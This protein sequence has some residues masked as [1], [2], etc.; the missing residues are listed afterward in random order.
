[1]HKTSIFIQKLFESQIGMTVNTILSHYFILSWRLQK[2]YKYIRNI[3]V[4]MNY[5]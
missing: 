1:M 2:M 5:W 3:Y 4:D